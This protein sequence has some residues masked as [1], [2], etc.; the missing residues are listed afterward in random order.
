VLWLGCLC[1]FTANY[2]AAVLT[3]TCTLFGVVVAFFAL[4]R[5]VAAWRSGERG[6]G[7]AVLVGAA[8]SGSI[9]VRPD[10]GLL[11]VAVV[12]AMLW[13]GLRRGRRWLEGVRPALLA[14]AVVALPLMLWGVRNWRVFH[15]IQPLAPRYANDP[16]EDV[17]F[18]FQRWYRT[19]AIDFKA[20]VDVYWSYDGNLLR[21]E[22]LPARAFDSPAQ[23]EETRA[24][25]AAYNRQPSAT[26]AFD[27][28]L[29]KIAEERVRAKPLR[30]YVAMP[31]ARELDMWLRPR[32]ELLKMPVDWWAVRAHPKRSIAEIAYAALDAV[33]LLL[34][35]VGVVV[36]SR[37]GWGG[38]GALA[39][40]MLGF[41][42][43]RCLLLL[44]LDN[45]EP[46]YTLEGFPVV[47]LMAGFCRAGRAGLAFKPP[48]APAP[49]PPQTSP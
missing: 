31:V 21:L 44:T 22:D 13:V 29:G 15:V 2:T 23:M 38:E 34:G 26:P 27:A 30:Y 41:V 46:R 8:L 1:P 16:G 43:L 9:F 6:L 33:Y 42:V 10:Q 17:P 32:T 4:E 28:A 45:A 12:P 7:W 3:E 37:R 18:G 19:W 20:T 39:A 35:V 11:A 5:W 40:A 25:Y 49:T 36:W 47:I 24:V 48:P 14:S